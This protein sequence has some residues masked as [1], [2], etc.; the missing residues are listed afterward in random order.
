MDVRAVRLIAA[1]ALAILV[2]PPQVSAQS[3]SVADVLHRVGAY[4]ESYLTRVQSIVGVETVTVQPIARDWSGEG[5][6]RTLVYELRLDWT[7]GAEAAVRRELI[8]VN[9]RVPRP[10]DEPKCMDSAAITTEPLEFL[11]PEN[12]TRYEFTDGGP[13]SVN[14]QPVTVLN[15]RT[16]VETP[17]KTTWDDGCGNI[18]PGRSR[19]RIWVKSGS[20]EVHRIDSGLIGQV[21]MQVP[22]DQPWTD[23][24]RNLTLERMDSSI[25]YRAFRFDNPDETLLLP[26]SHES[27]TVMRNA[28]SLRVR[29]QYGNYRRFVTGGRVI[30]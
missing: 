2:A 10:R 9:G 30:E 11:L 8:T 1:L 25:R 29:H 17:V 19:G 20:G 23:S 6:A 16:R 4:V 15:Y 27:V 22:R 5:L 26:T 14:G 3:A 28:A 12:R 18:D 13:A 21:D 7:P 24:R